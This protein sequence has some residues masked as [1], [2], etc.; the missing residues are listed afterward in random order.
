[1]PYIPAP[2][3]PQPIPTM[4]S[5]CVHMRL[6]QLRLG[7][8]KVLKRGRDNHVGRGRARERA[9][10]ASL[11]AT[12]CYYSSIRAVRLLANRI[13]N[14]NL[15]LEGDSE[16]NAGYSCR[17]QTHPDTLLLGGPTVDTPHPHPRHFE[18]STSYLFLFFPG[19]SYCTYVPV[20]L[21]TYRLQLSLQTHAMPRW[22]GGEG[23]HVILFP[24][25]WEKSG[26]PALRTSQSSPRKAHRGTS[27]QLHAISLLLMP[28]Y[29]QPASQSPR[30]RP[31]CR[32]TRA[33]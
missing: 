21:H 8:T 29:S 6:L 1:M 16:H 32:C 2:R 14:M 25:Q 28:D 9:M 18:C 22:P 19:P 13:H 26:W 20:Y 30:L 33:A 27:V 11:T 7:S 10:T 24:A 12:Q 5:T 15:Q 23:S 31:A 3:E 17:G 4:Y